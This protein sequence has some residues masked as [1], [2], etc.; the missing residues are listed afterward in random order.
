MKDD[1]ALLIL[2]F[3]ASQLIESTDE[4]QSGYRS[5]LLAA[6]RILREVL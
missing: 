3:L 4:W 6:Y 5:G 1:N 2:I